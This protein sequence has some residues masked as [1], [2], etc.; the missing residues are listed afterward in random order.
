MRQ[1]MKYGFQIRFNDND[2]PILLMFRFWFQNA[3]YKQKI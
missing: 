3:D 2:V 1:K